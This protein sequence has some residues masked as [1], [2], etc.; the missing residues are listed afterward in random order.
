M[1]NAEQKKT[2]ATK[3]RK[4]RAEWRE[5]YPDRGIDATRLQRVTEPQLN[6]LVAQL[7]EWVIQT[8][9]LQAKDYKYF[10]Y[11]TDGL[12]G[13]FGHPIPVM[14]PRAVR[15]GALFAPNTGFQ[16]GA[17]VLAC[18][19]RFAAYPREEC[20]HLCHNARC[21]RG[22]HLHWESRQKNEARKNCVGTF[23]APTQEEYT[24][25]KHEPRCVKLTYL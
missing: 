9:G 18:E 2:Q 17:V 6:A 22:D 24:L 5:Q 13:K 10:C 14:L 4:E 7:P 11:E 15:C 1:R 21:I 16:V 19:G 25:C 20:S 8:H 3:K 23:R 12:T